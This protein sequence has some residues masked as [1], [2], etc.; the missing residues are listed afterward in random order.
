[1]TYLRDGA[2]TRAAARQA[3]EALRAIEPNLVWH[4]YY[5][6]SVGLTFPSLRNPDLTARER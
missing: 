5:G 4:G 3:G 1:M 6:Y 2:S